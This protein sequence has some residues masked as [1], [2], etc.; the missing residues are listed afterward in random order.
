MSKR[1]EPFLPNDMFS[2]IVETMGRVKA[3]HTL[4]ACK[5]VRIT[6]PKGWKLSL[7]E[8][9]SIDGICSTVVKTDAS[10]FDVE[11]MPETLRKTTAAAFLPATIVNLERSLVFG[12]RVHG[13]FVMG[14]VDTVA[15]VL[16][17][18][19]QGRSRLISFTVPR[20]LSKYVVVHGSVSLNGV[21]LTVARKVRNVCTVA[22]IPHT[23][24]ATT[25]G[26]SKFGDALNIECDMVARYGLAAFRAGGTVNG[27]EARKRNH[28][29]R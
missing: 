1:Y 24:A 7:G 25:L 4:G 22:L 23:L 3:V 12:A 29:P 9:V 15:R 5:R 16:Q 8:S 10:S 27:N 13:H 28:T 20:A 11:Y 17:V 2:G 26:N 21:S 14:H 19:T 6:K 18:Q